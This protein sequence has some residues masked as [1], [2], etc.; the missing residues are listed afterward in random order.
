MPFFAHLYWVAH[1]E[2][3]L[4]ML[5]AHFFLCMQRKSPKRKPRGSGMRQVPLH[6]GIQVTVVGSKRSIGQK[7]KTDKVF[8]HLNHTSHPEHEVKG[9]GSH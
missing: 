8:A 9:H 2:A 5:S 1:G 4:N 6:L 7:K 3:P